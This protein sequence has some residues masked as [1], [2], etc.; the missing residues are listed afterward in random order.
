MTKVS[1][2]GEN[3]KLWT[4]GN[5]L[6]D[7][8]GDVDSSVAKRLGDLSIVLVRKGDEG[9]VTRLVGS[10]KDQAEL[11]GVLNNLYDMHFPV[12][13]VERLSEQ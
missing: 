1:K 7:V 13:R 12:L 4:P 2:H 5:Y 10:F 9:D 8:A 11:I 6:I 3:I